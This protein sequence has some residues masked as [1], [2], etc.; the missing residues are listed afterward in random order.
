MARNAVQ[1]QKEFR[2]PAFNRQYGTEKQYRALV[3]ALCWP[4]RSSAQP[5]VVG[6]RESGSSEAARRAGDPKN[7]GA[8]STKIK[9]LLRARPST[10]HL[11]AWIGRLG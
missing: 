8:A 6:S 1:I 4:D 10:W 9:G 3:V 5:V 11:V 2:D 7:T